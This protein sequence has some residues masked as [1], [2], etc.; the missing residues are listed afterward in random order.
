MLVEWLL[1]WGIV[2]LFLPFLPPLFQENRVSILPLQKAEDQISALQLQR[3]FAIS[4]DC[5]LCEG[6]VCFHTQG[7]E[8]RLIDYHHRLLLQPG[9]Q[10]F[11]QDAQNFS[12]LKRNGLIYVCYQREG[13]TY[14]V[15]LFPEEGVSLNDLPTLP[16]AT[17]E[18]VADATGNNE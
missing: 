2:C 11:F 1:T 18:F 13:D 3:I 9:S 16:D 14:E 17:D 15:P 10:V 8:F 4:Y 12:W 6:G 5:R 7:K